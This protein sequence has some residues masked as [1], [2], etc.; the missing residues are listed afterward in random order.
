MKS[1][2]HEMISTIAVT[3]TKLQ[4]HMQ[5]FRRVVNNREVGTHLLGLDFKAFDQ[6]GKACGTLLP[7]Q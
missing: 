4:A 3:S 2:G 5:P 6:S 1:V 7:E